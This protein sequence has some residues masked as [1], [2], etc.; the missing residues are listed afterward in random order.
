MRIHPAIPIVTAALLAG[1]AGG[2]WL[3]LRAE[4]PQA[5]AAPA[6]PSPGPAAELV[7]DTGRAV[8]A[9]DGKHAVT[10][11]VDEVI[12]LA[13]LVLPGDRVDVFVTQ[14]RM[15]FNA[16][17][18]IAMTDRVLHNVRVLAVAT[19]I[20]ELEPRQI[21][22]EVTPEERE[23]VALATRLGRLSLMLRSTGGSVASISSTDTVPTDAPMTTGH[24]PEAGELIAKPQ[25][26]VLR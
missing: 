17:S 26:A 11:P 12:G 8:V 14:K 3:P 10:I 25:G 16:P 1:M 19:E 22:I 21:T 6:P 20:R 13:G 4:A 5:E 18:T 9:A 7:G 2:T 23:I 24:A 15:G